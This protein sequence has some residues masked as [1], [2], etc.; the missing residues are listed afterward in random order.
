MNSLQRCKSC[1]LSNTTGLLYD[2]RRWLP[3]AVVEVRECVGSRHINSLK[4]AFD[5]SSKDA[6]I[7][8]AYDVFG[9]DW[10]LV[11]VD[12]GIG[13]PEGVFAQPK[14]GLGTSIISALAGQLDAQVVT[15]SGTQGTT[16]SV[17]H[18]TFGS[19]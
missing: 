17:T 3:G 16:V 2:W 12:N 6:R 14:S 9:K 4:H 5:E 13:K 10:K 19:R 7:T 1:V 8:I 11:V 18:S 15:V